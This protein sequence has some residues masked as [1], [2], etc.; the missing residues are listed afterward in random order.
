MRRAR[1]RENILEFMFAG[2]ST[3]TVY[4]EV[5]DSRMTFKIEKLPDRKKQNKNDPNIWFIKYFTGTDNYKHY[6][7][8]GSVKVVDKTKLEYKHSRKSKFEPDA[9]PVLSFMWLL[10]NHDKLPEEIHFYHEG[11]CGRCGRKLTVPESVESGYGPEC[12]KMI[13]ARRQLAKMNQ[14]ADKILL[15]L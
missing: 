12:W 4:N 2:R 14:M 6:S 5:T 13:G 7:F 1:I 11:I 10:D 9:R 3:F 8:L 15:G